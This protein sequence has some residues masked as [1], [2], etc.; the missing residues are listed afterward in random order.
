MHGTGEQQ[1]DEV[2]E[3]ASVVCVL[4]EKTNT[5]AW[6]AKNKARFPIL[7]LLAR[8]YLCIDATSCE[9]ERIFSACGLTLTNHRVAMH[10][11]KFECLVMIKQNS[12]DFKPTNS[13][14]RAEYSRCVK[15]DFVCKHVTREQYS[16]NKVFKITRKRKTCE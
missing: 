3:Y 2:D 6:W 9:P 13:E 5:L 10:P 15:E 14:I 11:I 12:C 4:N 1:L 7:F 16:Q 8:Q